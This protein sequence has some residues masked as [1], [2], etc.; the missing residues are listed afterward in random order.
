M[1]GRAM[2][3]LLT[4]LLRQPLATMDQFEH[5]NL[6]LYRLR[7]DYDTQQFSVELA[8]DTRHLLPLAV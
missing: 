8:N 3:I 5:R 6:C 4:T 1:H 7:Y 2:R